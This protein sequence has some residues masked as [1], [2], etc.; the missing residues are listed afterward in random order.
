MGNE[1]PF[2]PLDYW[3]YWPVAQFVQY[4]RY[5]PSISPFSTDATD[6]QSVRSVL[7]TWPR[8]SRSSCTD[9]SSFRCLHSIGSCRSV[10]RRFVTHDCGSL[11]PSYPGIICCFICRNRG[12]TVIQMPIISSSSIPTLYNPFVNSFQTSLRLKQRVNN[13][14]ILPASQ[15]Q[16]T[17]GIQDVEYIIN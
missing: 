13:S 1:C 6:F 8:N 7:H 4:W 17:T 3:P 14:E 15:R 12:G 16:R 5:W 9:L 2:I 10:L 11:I